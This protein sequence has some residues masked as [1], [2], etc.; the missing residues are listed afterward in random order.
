VRATLFI[1]QRLGKKDHNAQMT[2]LTKFTNTY[3]PVKFFLSSYRA[4]SDGRNGIRHLEER[5]EATTL[6]L[7][8]WK[9]MWFGTCAVLRTAIDLFQI[10][11]KSCLD[12]SIRD[13]VASEWECIKAQ[14]TNHTIFWE[15]L[16]RE[17]DNVVHGYQWQAYETW[18]KP[19]GTFRPAQLSILALS[20]D[21][22]RPVL[23]MRSG[24]FEGRNSLELLSRLLKNAPR[25]FGFVIHSIHGPGVICDART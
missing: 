3:I 13:E 15:F 8:E 20:D 21:G 1:I 23:L 17:R 24:P 5:L 6:V 2:D 4:L 19:D 7:S 22:A 10:D 16:K 25:I 11:A 12:T 14:K 18:I 9:V